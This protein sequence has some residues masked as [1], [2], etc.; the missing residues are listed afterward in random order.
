VIVRLGLPIAFA[1]KL[2]PSVRPEYERLWQAAQTAP[3]AG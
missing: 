3:S 1:E 2:D